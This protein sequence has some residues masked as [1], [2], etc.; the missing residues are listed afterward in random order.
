[1]L[2][3]K[4]GF[5]PHHFWLKNG[6]G[7]SLVELM[8]VVAIMAVLIA[9][10]FIFGNNF[11]NHTAVKTATRD[12]ASV[13]R[14]AHSKA[15]ARKINYLVVF[16]N[17]EPPD[18]QARVWVQERPEGLD[19][20]MGTADEG[21]FDPDDSSTYNPVFGTE[22]RLSKRV[23]IA[24]IFVSYPTDKPDYYGN[25]TAGDQI[26]YLPFY[27][28]G[29]SVSASVKLQDTKGNNQYKVTVMYSTSRTKVQRGW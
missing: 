19:G 29:T 16:D 22:R 2:K 21:E 12:I 7:F 27:W 4:T 1:M 13:M 14:M 23:Q 17:Q 5:T 15:G 11:L 8:V 18:T 3:N 6:A 28:D 10:S 25:I 26:G 20:I 9:T 24:S